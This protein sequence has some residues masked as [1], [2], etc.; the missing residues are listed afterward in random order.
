[1]GKRYWVRLTGLALAALLLAG[2]TE[3]ARQTEQTQS[4][5]EASAPSSPADSPEVKAEFGLSFRRESGFNPFTCTDLTN[6]TVLSLLYQGLFAVT[7]DYEAEPVLCEAFSVSD[8]LK[9][10]TV[11]LADARFSDGSR[12]TPQD[13]LASL[14]AARESTLYRKRFAHLVSAEAKGSGVVF[15]VDTPMENLPLL[16]DFPVTKAGTEALPVPVGTGPYV[17]QDPDGTPCLQR[18]SDW[19]SSAPLAVS[20]DVIT[21]NE[22][23][24]AIEIRNDFEFGKTDV[25]CA[26]PGASS[27]VDYRCDYE[28]WGCASGVMLYL[29]CNAARGPF[30]SAAVRAA[31]TH[32]VDRSGL[33]ES[34]YRGFAEPACLPASPASPFYS[35]EL[36]QRCQYE[37]SLLASAVSEAG[38]RDDVVMLLVL[39]DDPV[40]AAA[41]ESIAAGLTLC[42]LK[43]TVQAESREKYRSSLRN[44]DYDLYLG[45]VRLSANFDLSAFFRDGGDLDY[46]G[47]SDSTIYGLCLSALE[48]SGNYYSLHQAVLA[49]GHL[50]P[51]LFRTYAVYAN[52]NSVTGLAPGLDNV[53]HE[54]GGRTLE[55]A[56]QETPRAEPAATES[57]T[58]STEETGAAVP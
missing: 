56:R 52:R 1:M 54:T 55:E 53:F 49:D 34:I 42:G 15:A 51:V 33:A 43:V 23:E 58:E 47:I 14:D 11:T 4:S 21:L 20:Q 6:R 40:R 8:D 37:P 26:D 46:G 17:L 57:G 48:N 41:A 25:V 19:W 2:C 39:A 9:T 27:Y 16:L 18:T 24:S 31:L 12:L 35:Q 50:C 32:A 29:G 36:A 22:A 10:W 44:G 5:T 28:L 38:K 7:S 30:Q 3:P 13:V 45:Q